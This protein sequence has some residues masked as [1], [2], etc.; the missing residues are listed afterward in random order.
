VRTW[1]T[2]GNAKE[3]Q[4]KGDV[5]EGVGGAVDDKSTKNEGKMDQ[6]TGK[7]QEGFGDLKE[8]MKGQDR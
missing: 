2:V 1:R 6:V 5:K 3:K 8:K 4:V 7:V